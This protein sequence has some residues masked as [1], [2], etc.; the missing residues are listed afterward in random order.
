[1]ERPEILW[2]VLWAFQLRGPASKH[3]LPLDF[4][5]PFSPSCIRDLKDRTD[6]YQTHCRANEAWYV[7]R[8]EAQARK[9][10]KR[11]RKK[12]HKG[13]R[14]KGGV[15]LK[16]TMTGGEEQAKRI[17]MSHLERITAVLELWATDS[18]PR[19][20]MN[21]YESAW[22]LL[23]NHPRDEVPSLLVLLAPPTAMGPEAVFRNRFLSFC[24][25]ASAADCT[26]ETIEVNLKFWMEAEAYRKA[27]HES[28]ES[29]HALALSLFENYVHRDGFQGNETELERVR[30]S[31]QETVKVSSIDPLLGASLAT[32]M[33]ST[34]GASVFDSVQNEVFAWLQQNPYKQWLA[35]LPAHGLL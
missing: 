33:E 27:R 19:D 17:P 11:S 6:S 4:I 7:V 13:S 20:W 31:L 30:Q 22:T 9:E 28:Q 2:N 10:R 14:K 18:P 16:Q 25:A 21:G 29:R 1:M 35:S 3:S 12:S 34:V 32:R 23:S 26:A 5:A 8:G 15:K 24:A